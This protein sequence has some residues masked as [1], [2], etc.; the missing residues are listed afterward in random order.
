M[1]KT[2]THIETKLR[3]PP[4]HKKYKMV[5]SMQLALLQA[6]RARVAGSSIRLPVLGEIQLLPGKVTSCKAQA[7]HKL[8]QRPHKRRPK[9]H[10]NAPADKQS[11]LAS[12]EKRCDPRRAWPQQVMRESSSWLIHQPPAHTKKILRARAFTGLPFKVAM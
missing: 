7:L 8:C 3:R 1:I 12:T 4:K 9:C 2:V 6:R 10:R 11:A 5:A